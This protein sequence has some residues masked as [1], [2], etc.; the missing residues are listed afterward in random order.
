MMDSTI[1]I[2]YTLNK[3]DETSLDENIKFITEIMNRHFLGLYEHKQANADELEVE[4]VFS[5]ETPLLENEY[6]NRE[7][8]ESL[9][10]VFEDT[11]FLYPYFCKI[12]RNDD[13]R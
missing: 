7:F 13:G 3:S 5:I 11:S 2:G 6:N 1:N 9:K 4:L 10:I 8:F 12:R